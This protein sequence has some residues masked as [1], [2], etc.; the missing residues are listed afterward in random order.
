VAGE[1]SG[2]A[3]ARHWAWPGTPPGPDA[4]IA[5]GT[6]AVRPATP[7]CRLMMGAGQ[8]QRTAG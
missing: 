6:C 4:D 5:G 3:D 1:G 2:M 7:F 8:A